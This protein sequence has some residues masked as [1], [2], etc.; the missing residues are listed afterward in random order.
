MT[1]RPRIA[2]AT[3]SVAQLAKRWSVSERTIRREIDTGWLRPFRI[4][5]VIRIL[6]EEVE[7]FEAG[8]TDESEG[9][10]MQPA[11]RPEASEDLLSAQ[12]IVL[13]PNSD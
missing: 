13:S 3:F 10:G 7:R 9:A 4:Q 5:G 12:V 11:K 8:G 6:V 1:D 2:V